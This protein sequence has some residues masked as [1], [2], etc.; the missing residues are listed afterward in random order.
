MKPLVSTGLRGGL[1]SFKGAVQSLKKPIRKTRLLSALNVNSFK[2]LRTFK[3]KKEKKN[4]LQ[5]SALQLL[6]VKNYLT[7]LE[8]I[9]L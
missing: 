1:T 7:L 4:P 3:I 2:R 6:F 9:M 8:T 5:G